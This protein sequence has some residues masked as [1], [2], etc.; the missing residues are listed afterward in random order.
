MFGT[1]PLRDANYEPE[2][3]GEYVKKTF[4]KQVLF[5]HIVIFVRIRFAFPFL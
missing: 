2:T 3:F 1:L 4:V 5:W